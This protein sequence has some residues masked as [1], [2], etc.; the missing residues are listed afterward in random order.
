M[1]IVSIVFPVYNEEGNLELLHEK[2]TEVVDTIEG[3]DFEFIFVD[4]CSKDRSP[5]ILE[6]L[7]DRDPRVRM[8]R[9]SRN[10]GSHA[11]ITAGLRYCC[12][13]SAIIMASDMQD[14]PSLIPRLLSERDQGAKV[15]FAGRAKR[16]GES[17]SVLFFSRI[18]WWVMNHFTDLNF[19]PK[20]MDVLWMDRIVI[21]AFLRS[22]E[23]HGSI[24]MLIAWLGFPQKNIEYVKEARHAGESGWTYPKKIKLFLDSLFSFS[25]LP[26]RFISV[27]GVFTIAVGFLMALDVIYQGMTGDSVEGWAS[28]ALIVLGLGGLQLMILGVLGEYVWRTF[29]ESRRRPFYV[30]EQAKGL[31]I[32]PFEDAASRIAQLRAAYQLPPRPLAERSTT[33]DLPRALGAGEPPSDEAPKAL[34]EAAAE[35]SSLP[36]TSDDTDAGGA[37]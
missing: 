11:A 4:D 2:I 10:C 16:E 27:L 7:C 29:D 15:V 28:L 34:P 23:K 6:S 30:I 9:F 3:E 18:Y 12:G 32:D 8:V 31:Q 5:Q 13:D 36:D 37:S 33:G 24:F 17:A 21:E 25:T 19:A 22:P 26:I 14:P 20:G 35:A 1:G